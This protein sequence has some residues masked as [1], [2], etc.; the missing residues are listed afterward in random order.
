[1]MAG[2]LEETRADLA[3]E[4]KEQTQTPAV[5]S[6]HSDNYV[7]V[8]DAHRNYLRVIPNQTIQQQQSQEPEMF[9]TMYQDLSQVFQPEFHQWRDIM[10]HFLRADRALQVA[11]SQRDV[12]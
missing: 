3:T 4:Q 12:M 9:D 5:K 1:M 10:R 2:W 7:S 6:C 11:E 8:V